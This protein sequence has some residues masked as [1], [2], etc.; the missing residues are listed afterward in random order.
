MENQKIEHRKSFSTAKRAGCVCGHIAVST[1]REN[2]NRALIRHI[3]NPQAP[4]KIADAPYEHRGCKLEEWSGRYGICT[5]HLVYID[6]QAGGVDPHQT[7]LPI[8]DML[9]HVKQE[10][11]A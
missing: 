1:S 8:E 6:Q 2:A 5:D 3:T 9:F 4:G 7:A 10:N 11:R